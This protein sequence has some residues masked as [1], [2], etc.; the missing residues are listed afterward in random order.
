MRDT[1]SAKATT[2]PRIT[3]MATPTPR[4]FSADREMY[5]PYPPP[6]LTS[7]W[8]HM[9][10]PQR[11]NP[12][13]PP[14][15]K[16]RINASWETVDQHWH[17]DKRRIIM[18]QREHSRFH[19]AWS[20]P[21]YGSPADQ[22]AYRKH[23]REVLKQQMSDQDALKRQQLKDKVRESEAAVE[24]DRQCLVQ[25]YEAFSKKNDYLKQYRDENKR[26][27]ESQWQQRRIERMLENHYDREVLRYNP[28]N[29]SGTLK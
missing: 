23:F 14:I 13:A 11:I 18:Q 20:K 22:E 5:G 3:P 7:I 17:N 21:F 10:I 9:K 8:D 1:M 25:D 28:I 4:S 24:Y 16:R 12:L 26:F 27:M 29:W 6:E 19:S 15:P 2:L